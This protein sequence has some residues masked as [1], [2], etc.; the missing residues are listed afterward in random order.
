MPNLINSTHELKKL[1]YLYTIKDENGL[2]RHAPY[3]HQINNE[4]FICVNSINDYLK[5]YKNNL[6]HRSQLKLQ[7]G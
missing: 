4:E 3:F 5:I 7:F 1:L 2:E 6:K